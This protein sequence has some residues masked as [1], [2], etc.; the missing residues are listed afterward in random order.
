[1]PVALKS[2]LVKFARITAKIA[3][4]LIGFVLVL[5][6]A[7]VLVNSFDVPLSDQAKALLTPPPNRYSADDNLYLAMAGLEGAGERPT[8][9]MG[10]E[11]IAAYNQALESMLANPD[12]ALDVN[13]KWDATKLAFAGKL[14]LG[15]QRT[16][17][18]WAA[19]KS[20]RQNIAAH[21]ASNQKLYQ[22]YLSLHL[23][24]GYY[25]TARPSYLA[26]V[27]SAPRQL[28][29]LF[30]GSVAD[31]IQTGT[32]QQQREAL[33]DL[34]DDLQT[35]RTVLKGDGTLISKMLAAAYLHGDLILLADLIEDPSSDLQRLDDVLGA[36]VL[37][38]GP[39]DYR[40]GNAFLAEWRGVATLYKTITAANEYTEAAAPPSWRKRMENTFEAHFFKINATENIS[41]PQAAHWAA[42]MDSE[43]SQF[44]ENRELN[45][46]WLEKNQPH[47]SLSSFY[48]PVGKILVRVA[49]SQNDSYALR[50]YDIAAYQRLVCLAYQLKHQHA[51]TADVPAFLKAH[52]EWSTHPVDGKPFSWNAQQSELAVNT[53][54]EHPKEQRFSVILH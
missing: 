15:P 38:F 13:K 43:P 50:V 31:R 34:Q 7:W 17:S 36:L 12:L 24:H 23:L 18:V 52:P 14:E 41:A 5:F 35:W 40:I 16:A 28:R 4:G 39:K 30:L 3:A 27:I 26:P 21:L 20:H 33:T 22:R 42:L 48:N 53:L 51:A 10:Q 32:P 37:P 46:Q 8:I 47:F 44:L 2:R 1:M 29:A 11:R 54:G 19:T 49:M 25:E 9:E 6:L 45:R